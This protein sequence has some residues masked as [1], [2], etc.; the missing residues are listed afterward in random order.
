MSENLWTYGSFHLVLQHW[1]WFD[2]K[3]IWPGKTFVFF[4]KVSIWEASPA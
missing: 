2:W 4:P 3:G 1:L